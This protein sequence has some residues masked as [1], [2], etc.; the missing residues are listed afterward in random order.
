VGPAFFYG[1][2]TMLLS[3]KIEAQIKPVLERYGCDLVVGAFL[4]EKNGRVLRLFIERSGA[5]AEDGPGVDLGLCAS[6][7]RDLS[8]VLDVADVI[9]KAYTLEV[10]SPGIERPL[11]RSADY[12]RFKGQIISLKTKRAVDGHRR[13]KGLLDG[14]RDGIV[15]LKTGKDQIVTIP[16]EQIAKANLV[17][18]PKRFDANAGDR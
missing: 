1:V 2:N 6:V 3:A 13:F 15:T 16:H 17:F 12:E 11:V 10:S 9:D 8:A 18:D 4:N 14:L 7:S 5:T